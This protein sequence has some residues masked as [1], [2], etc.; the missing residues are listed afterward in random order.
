[1]TTKYLTGAYPGGYTVANSVSFLDITA[2]A[3]IGGTGVVAYSAPMNSLSIDN[4]G[5]VHA[6]SG[7]GIT[8][9]SINANIVKGMDNHSA[10][11]EGSKSG[12]AGGDTT[13]ANFGTIE[14]LGAS[15]RYAG[16]KLG[17]NSTA[18]NGSS[19][20]TNALIEGY[21][22]I[23]G[24]WSTISNFGSIVGTA[25]LGIY[26]GGHN[27]SNSVMVTNGSQGDRAANIQGAYSCVYLRYTIGTVINYGTISADVQKAVALL[28]GGLID[29]FGAISATGASSAGIKLAGKVSV[30]NGSAQDTTASIAGVAVGITSS[31]NLSATIVNY[32]TVSATGNS[33]YGVVLTAGGH[34]RNGSSQDSSALIQGGKDG[35]SLQG[36]RATIVNFGTIAGG[37]SGGGVMMSGANDVLTNGA[38]THTTALIGGSGASV[39]SGTADTITNYGTISGL[40]LTS[41][42]DVLK[43]EAGSVFETPV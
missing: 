19:T 5:T 4:E 1:M 16:V 36:N 27:G 43:V 26:F 8:I 6:T 40:S 2:T 28:Y 23:S 31:G 25:D 38:P 41:T 42:T 21:E 3:S 9:F 13:V 24:Y 14:G 32:G 35:V 7:P 12:V 20:D 34:I 18:T 10:L 33:G 22:G 11:I 37:P 39:V 30:F 29:N 17:T 15:F